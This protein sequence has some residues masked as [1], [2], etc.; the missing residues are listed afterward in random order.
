MQR[1]LLVFLAVAMAL[2]VGSGV[3]FA[4]TVRCGGGPCEGTARPD[5]LKGSDFRDSI[6]GFG[7][8]D[9]LYGN[10]GND[11]LRGGLG[12]DEMYGGSGSDGFYGEGGADLLSGG[13]G[14]DRLTGGS[15]KDTVYGGSED[16]SIA[17]QDGRFDV[18][19][20]GPGSYDAVVMDRGL[21]RIR[22]CEN[23]YVYE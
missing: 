9:R 22:N 4:A 8:E 23:V 1:T 18:V 11:L 7:A 21:D 15:G 6:Y 5:V 3:A 2:V 12:A 17:V 20:C 13:S 16:D 19:N 10:G 14:R